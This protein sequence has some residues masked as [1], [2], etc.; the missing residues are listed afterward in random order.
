MNENKI[1][2]LHTGDPEYD[3]NFWNFTRGY[4]GCEEALSMCVDRST[5]AYPLPMVAQNKYSD[6][7]RKKSLFR[8]IGTNI[9]ALNN[10]YR[11]FAK[12]C[13]DMAMWVPE[14]GSIPIYEGIEDF[15]EHKLESCKLAAFVKLDED[16]IHDVSFNIE[17]YLTERL[18]KNFAKGEEHGFVNGAGKA[19]PVGILAETGGAEIGTTATTLTFEDIYKLF[20]SVKP[21]YRT[22]GSFMMNDETS[23]YLRTLK[24]DAGNFLWRGSA[25]ALMGKP[26]IISNEMPSIGVSAKPEAFGD[27]SYYWVVDRKLV[28]IRTLKE[29]FTLHDQIGYLAFEF[30]DG[31][32]VRSDAVKVVQITE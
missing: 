29:K 4:E 14:G 26:V 10:G 17:N 27:F 30:V 21:E 3:I 13:E 31:R 22:N 6:A 32:L 15:T 18:A 11:I 12:D 25:D 9:K 24:D 28:S 2:T 16:F 1:I 8:R 20:F 5:G 23:L 7:L 19:E